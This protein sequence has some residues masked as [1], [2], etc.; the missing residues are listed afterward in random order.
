M[1]NN[2]KEISKN[3][4]KYINIINEKFSEYI[5]TPSTV[6]HLCGCGC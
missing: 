1:S 4:D 5:K 3:D 6:I 2:K